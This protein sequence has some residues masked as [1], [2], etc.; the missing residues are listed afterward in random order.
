MLTI[1][2]SVHHKLLLVVGVKNGTYESLD[3]D[4]VVDG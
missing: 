4:E 1:S 2:K 3:M